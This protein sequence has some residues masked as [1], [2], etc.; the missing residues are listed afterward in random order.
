MGDA[1]DEPRWPPKRIAAALGLAIL[2]T[3][4]FAAARDGPPLPMPGWAW[5]EVIAIGLIGTCLTAVLTWVRPNNDC[6][7]RVVGRKFLLGSMVSFVAG[8]MLVEAQVRA[9]E[10]LP[11]FGFVASPYWFIAIAAGLFVLSFPFEWALTKRF[12]AIRERNVRR[13]VDALMPAPTDVAVDGWSNEELDDILAEFSTQYGLEG[14]TIVVAGNGPI[15]LTFSQPIT[16]DEFM[17]L[18][19]YL[20]YPIGKDLKNRQVVAVG[21]SRVTKGMKFG[22]SVPLESEVQ[23]HVPSDDNSYDC[24]MAQTVAGPFLIDFGARKPRKSQNKR[25]SA[26]MIALANS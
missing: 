7:R 4:G 26:T 21:R 8:I 16:V 25:Q 24:V 11:K 15:R 1:S 13:A 6:A 23:F 18:V 14:G 9:S 20:P 17:F 5:L 10:T 3:A 22:P 12:P 19:N 2:L